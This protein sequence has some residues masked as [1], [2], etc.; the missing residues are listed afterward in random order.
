MKLFAVNLWGTHPDC[1]NDDCCTGDNF[2]TL[3]AAVA[4]ASNPDAFF[5]HAKHCAFIEIVSPEGK[6]V[7]ERKIP[8]TKPVEYGCHEFANLQGMAGGIDAYNDAMGY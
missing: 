3:A 5:P 2:D 7:I 4:C 6:L 1:G 8:K